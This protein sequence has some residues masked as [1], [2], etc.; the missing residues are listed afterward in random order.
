MTLIAPI[1]GEAY[2]IKM[3]WRQLDWVQVSLAIS[4]LIED[5][6][7]LPVTLFKTK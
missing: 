5:V 3:P 1:G 2:K 4:Q 6:I 7:G